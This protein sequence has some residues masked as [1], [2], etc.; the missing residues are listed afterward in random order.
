MKN[1]LDKIASRISRSR[2]MLTMARMC[3]DPVT[4]VETRHPAVSLT[5]DDGP[6]P[7]YTRRLLKILEENNAKA[8]FFM[9]GEA[10]EKYPELV[11]TAAKAGHAIGNHSENHM[12]LCQVPSPFLRIKHLIAC[13]KKLSPYGGKLFRPPFGAFNDQIKLDALLMGYKIILWNASAQDWVLQK[14]EEIEQKIIDRLAPGT[15]FLLHD[16]MYHRFPGMEPNDRG[17]M[18]DGL[19]KALKKIKDKFEFVT[20][21]QLIRYGRPV[22]HWPHEPKSP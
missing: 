14:P 16:S 5:F 9:V 7:A 12:N 20:V 10:A 17:T 8:T 15:I 4:H 21:P 19:E 6:H 11:K 13:R 3:P 1:L 2:V 22:C 18:L